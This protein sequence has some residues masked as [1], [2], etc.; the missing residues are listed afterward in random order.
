MTGRIGQQYPDTAHVPLFHSSLGDDAI[1]LAKVAGLFL[2]EWQQHVLRCSLNF[3]SNGKFAAQD[4]CLICCRQNGKNSI[5]EAREL[6]GLFLI[7]TD[8]TIVHS[9]HEF[10]TAQ[11]GYRRLSNLVENSDYLRELGKPKCTNSGAAGTIVRLTDKRFKEKRVVFS[12]RSKGAIRGFSVDTVIFD[13]AYDLPEASLEAMSPTQT[14]VPNA[15]A[16]YLSSTGFDDSEVLRRMRKSGLDKAPNVGFFEFK[17]DDDCDPAD[18]EQWYKANPALG[19]RI[20]EDFLEG[21][22]RKLSPIGFAREHL[23]LW[24]SLDIDALIPSGLWRSLE[25]T[26]GQMQ[27]RGNGPAIVGDVSFAVDADPLGE[28]ATVS[29][30]GFNSDRMYHVE[31]HATAEGINWVPEFI[32]LMD[33]KFKP[34]S[35][36]IDPQGPI[37]AIIPQLDEL[38]VPYTAINARDVITA[39]AQFLEFCID[40]RLRHNPGDAPLASAVPMAVKREINKAGGWAWARKDMEANISPL[41]AATYALYGFTAKSAERKRGRRVW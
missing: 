25:Y 30:A 40:N 1:N 13:E 34:K 11:E 31:T 26:P 38:G 17:A 37:S 35:I 39:C 27:T 8:K 5:V 33:E 14:A 36:I 18:R 28:F 22:L 29:Y 7:D 16:W 3:K 23:G 41:V 32:K 12:A 24:T 4:M 21:Q 2:D 6:A 20:T 10:R 9:A 19:I 15:Q